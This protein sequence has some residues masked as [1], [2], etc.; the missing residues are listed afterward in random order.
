ME[1]I[2]F[3]ESLRI[4]IQLSLEIHWSYKQHMTC[5]LVVTVEAHIPYPANETWWWKTL[6]SC[7][8]SIC[9]RLKYL[10]S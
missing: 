1:M 7:G 4:H 2:S 5:K 3:S 10:K 8:N 9:N 6:E